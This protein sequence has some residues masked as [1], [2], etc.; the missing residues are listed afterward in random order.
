M[1]K[2]K[3]VKFT[4][5]RMAED[6]LLSK[7]FHSVHS[8]VYKTCTSV[9]SYNIT[10]AE[11]KVLNKINQQLCQSMFGKQL[12][13]PGVDYIISLED[14]SEFYKFIET[15]YNK[16]NNINT[17]GHIQK[18]GYIRINSVS[19]VPYCMKNSMKYV[20]LFYFEA[21]TAVS[22]PFQII[23][24]ENWDLAY[25]KFCCKLQGI[26]QELFYGDFCNVSNI[27]EVKNYFPP[28]T[29]FEEYW[30]ARMINVQFLTN[31]NTD[32]KN[33][34]GSWIRVPLNV[35]I[36]QTLPAPAPVVPQNMPVMMNTD[37]N[38][39]QAMVYV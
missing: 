38:R 39:W 15:C 8:D 9:K 16:L 24:L 5:I 29:K 35:S 27:D 2:G 36:P 14:V 31:V 33:S 17:T 28:E 37:H 22:V 20:P 4:S 26:K 19:I 21:Q 18:C 11:A 10:E 13:L 3:P 25:L 32:H 6:H 7:Y 23:Q 30:P 34:P 1:I 12:F